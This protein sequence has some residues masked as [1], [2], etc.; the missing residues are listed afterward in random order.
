MDRRHGEQ[1]Q[2]PRPLD[3]NSQITLVTGAHAG[4]ATRIDFAPLADEAAQTANI[5]IVNDLHLVHA[6]AAH[7]SAWWEAPPSASTRRP[8]ASS[9]HRHQL[10][11]LSFNLHTLVAI[12]RF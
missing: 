3:G 11:Y 12:V 10:G 5:L 7:S 8:A 4:L 6:E 9:S 1:G 2:M